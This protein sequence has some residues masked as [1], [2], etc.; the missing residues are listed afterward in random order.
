M[1]ATHN[2]HQEA[3][4]AGAS[5][6]SDGGVS[7]LSLDGLR[8]RGPRRLAAIVVAVALG[9]G[10]LAWWAHWQDDAGDGDRARI[11][12]SR[13]DALQAA[14]GGM[15]AFNTVDHAHIRETVDGWLE[16]SAGALHREVRRDRAT[17]VARARKARTDSSAE[18]LQTAVAGFDEDAGKATVLGVLTI[19]T[20]PS[21]GEA[22][23]RTSRFRVL[24]QR[25]DSA[26]KITYL[27]TVGAGA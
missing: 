24:V 26:W 10:A 19:R 4:P 9:A 6:S 7:R 12:A 2:H 11:V 8:G 17:I 27:E 1:S 23:T 22:T 25:I 20:A 5:S 3:E 18:V 21:K 13:E 14:S 16:V 15:V